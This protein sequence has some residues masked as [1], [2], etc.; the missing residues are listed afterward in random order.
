[1]RRRSIQAVLCI[2]LSLILASPGQA[3]FDA[4][5]VMGTVSD[6]Q[7]KQLAEAVVTLTRGKEVWEVETDEKGLF[8]FRDLKPGNY[9]IQVAQEGYSEAVY[10]PVNI[11]LGRVTTVQ[12][13][14]SETVE[15]TIVVTS[16][17]PAGSAGR[18]SA[19]LM[20][21]NTELTT[22]PRASDP[23]SVG[24]QAAGVLIDRVDATAGEPVITKTPGASGGATLYTLD[25]ADVTGLGRIEGPVISSS[26]G[27]IETVEVVTGGS[28]IS[29][30]TPGT[31]INLL[32]RRGSNGIQFN[33][34]A[35]RTERDDRSTSSS[36][37]AVGLSGSRILD[38][39]EFGVDASGSLV[40]DRLWAWATYESQDIRRQVVGGG[41]EDT[42]ARNAAIKLSA[43][44]GASSA[45]VAYHHGDRDRAGEGAGLDRA[46][47]TT[48]LESKPSEVLRLEN[49]HVFGSN[50]FLTGR[51]AQVDSGT[52]RVPLGDAGSDI[53]LGE[54]GLWSGTFGTFSYGQ[55]SRS[56]LLDGAT[57]R[58]RGR[59][60][61]HEVRFGVSHQSLLHSTSERWGR[62][63]LLHLAGQ[64]FGTPFDIVRLERPIDFA[65]EQE[66]TAFWLQDS[67]TYDHFT[68]DFGLRHDLQRGIND[69]GRLGSNPLFPELLPA[70]DYAGGGSIHWSSLSPRLAMAYAFGS[71][72]RTVVRA[73]Y[74]MFA[75]QLYADLVSRVSPAV[76]TEV[77]L[78]FEDHDRNNRFD[79]EEPHF[80]LTYLGINP[81][82]S[83]SGQSPHST[84]QLL[85]P[86]RTDELRLAVEHHLPAG[87]D[88]SL[89]HVDRTITGIL[90]T[91]RII[92]D[93]IGRVRLAR[94]WDYELD[95]IY[96]GRLPGGDP[97][98]A[99]IYSLRGGLEYTGGNLL[100]NGGRE[101]HYQA[102][103]LSMI[104]HLSGRWMLRGHVTA[105]D[106]RWRLGS[107]FVDFDDP[108]N[109]VAV[110]GDDASV[111]QA[112]GDGDVVAPPAPGERLFLNSR[113]SFNVGTLVQLAP[114]SRWGLDVAM[115]LRGRE[116]FPLPYTVAWV[117]GGALREVQ[118]TD[119][120]DSV[121][122]DDVFLLDLRFEKEL[123]LRALR[124]AISLDVFNLLDAGEVLERERQLTSPLADQVRETLSPRVLRLGLRLAI[125]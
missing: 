74:S 30:S 113:W 31:R 1:M 81:N 87:V 25:G 22:I 69:S 36:E 60:A 39:A 92:R 57:Y 103:T 29:L 82:V 73:S 2:V 46:F 17:P 59:R 62:D 115:N 100:L 94:S 12:V 56:W 85:D 98:A 97:F 89:E 37:D 34:R 8:Q 27:S 42:A 18:E 117:E 14:M 67:V 28:D 48:L 11:R 112:D 43:Q 122:L 123:R 119:R 78:G 63:S 13:Q 84:D 45:S 109:V 106:W 72:R 124:A 101:Q 95:T 125:D 90:E 86:E 4:G 111:S 75:S 40:R 33:A 114:R 49:T 55:D 50:L 7:G 110:G 116:G 20:L 108:T 41:R 88:L 64:N 102:T 99:P 21:E 24:A 79:P 19:H 107:E 120:T 47:E 121:R 70:V 35:S 61:D 68:I 23:W 32:T 118:A 9:T 3:R 58:S 44:A 38:V 76:D 16:E 65:V 80:L 10:E 53:A 52:A 15:E 26:L 71:E 5:E 66:R 6:T 105:S 51:Y 77:Y 93:D 54:D 104:R 83:N 96:A 91:R